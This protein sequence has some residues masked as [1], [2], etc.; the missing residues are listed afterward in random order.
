MSV[1]LDS[2]NY[3]R[4][5]I[6]DSGKINIYT[7][8]EFVEKCNNSGE[9][10][11]D[12]DRVIKDMN[13]S[14]KELRALIFKNHKEERKKTIDYWQK[15]LKQPKSILNESSKDDG[16]NQAIKDIKNIIE[17]HKELMEAEPRTIVVMK[18]YDMPSTRDF[19]KLILEKD[20]D[21]KLSDMYVFNRC[22]VE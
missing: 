4:T 1:L 21:A 15:I 11:K 8:L 14:F 7:N 9:V 17:Q 12:I 16:S 22:D 2:S 20:L 6:S 19:F 5:I 3:K 13:K 18:P 10:R